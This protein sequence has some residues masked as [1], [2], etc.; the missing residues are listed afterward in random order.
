VLPVIITH[1]QTKICLTLI[2]ATASWRDCAA[3]SMGHDK[4]FE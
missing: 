4:L 2:S 1:E 3:A